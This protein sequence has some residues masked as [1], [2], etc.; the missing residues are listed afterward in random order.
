METR[1]Q[2]RVHE[3]LT[4]VAGD[5]REPQASSGSEHGRLSRR[6]AGTVGTT[7]AIQGLGLVSG[8]LLA[9]LLGVHDRGLLAALV[10]WP[11][12]AVHAGDLGGPIANAFFAATRPERISGLVANSLVLTGLQA[13]PLGIIA[14]VLMFLSLRQYGGLLPA[15]LAFIAVY[16]PAN[17]GYRYLNYINLGRSRFDLYNSGR[18]ALQAGYV[19]GVLILFVAGQHS[20]IL[21]LAVYAL[22]HV[23]AVSVAARNLSTYFSVK[24]RASWDLIRATAR[25]GFRAHLGNLAPVD[26]MQL[27]LAAVVVLLGP[28][29]AGL[30]AIAASVGLIIRAYGGALGTVAMPHVASAVDDKQRRVNAGSLFRLSIVMIVPIAI[31]IFLLAGLLVPLVYGKQFAGAVP[32]VRVLVL[33]MVAAALRQVLGDCLRGAGRPLTGTISEVSGWLIAIIGLAILVPLQG[34]IG[35]AV[36][37]SL[38]YGTTLLISVAFA[39]RFGMTLM[40]LFVPTPSDLRLAFGFGRHWF[41][42]TSLPGG[43]VA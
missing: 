42:R 24:L 5:S 21:A 18:L 10:L 25:Y 37:V 39:R 27:D 36:A 12:V 9:R 1:A 16:V 26:M 11:M 8:A 20:V 2:S 17:L 43:R 19:L 34:A 3:I 33:G 14:A 30:Y 15:G 35:A 31:A 7:L 23:I 6:I 41:N 28:R 22:C 38:S 40:Q 29:D 4:G 32:I 13:V